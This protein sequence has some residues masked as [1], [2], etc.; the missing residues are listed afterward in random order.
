MIE[1]GDPQEGV[2]EGYSVA[3]SMGA[4]ALVQFRVEEKIINNGFLE[5][6]AIE[7]TGYAIKRR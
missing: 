1:L 6:P 5:V 2:Q 4:D 7:V 3:T